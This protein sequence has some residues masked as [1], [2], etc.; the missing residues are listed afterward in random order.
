MD[1]DASLL[2]VVGRLEGP[3]NCRRSGQEGVGIGRDFW[4]PLRGLR[5]RCLS[6]DVSRRY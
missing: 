5:G 1:K 4:W 3:M 6:D 2:R